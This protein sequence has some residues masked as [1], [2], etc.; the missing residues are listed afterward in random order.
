MRV[1]IVVNE[2]GG[3]AI[4]ES[5][6]TLPERLSGLF[7]A[8]G[9]DAH[10]QLARPG[11]LAEQFRSAAAA[12]PDVLV[13]VG[14]DGTVSCGADAAV[15]AGIT[16]GVIP[17]GTFNHFARD[18]RIPIALEAAVDTI[19]AG[20]VQAV[21]VAEL[22]GRVFINNSAIGLYPMMVQDRE[23]Q[24]HRLG[25]SKRVAMIVACLRAFRHFHRHRLAVRI[26]G[27]EAPISTPLMFVGN[28][29][30]ETALLTMGR[31]A[32]LD[33]GVLSIRALLVESPLHLLGLALRGLFWGFDQQRD[34]ANLDS[35]REAVI[36]SLQP[37]LRVSLDGETHLF[38]T[39]LRYR[40]LPRAL[41][42]LVPAGLD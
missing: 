14:G 5:R 41:H 28:N 38:E 37:A 24:R 39:P 8:R 13:A 36:L 2:S 31:R 15:K 4:G 30:Y 7:R 12:R 20:R 6:E 35:A 22:N 42:L 3:N 27:R 34:F 40:I 10:V 11:A 26:E 29:R 21:D 25:R 18:A 17:R 19:S 9:I 1:A 32:R 16:L 23:A 33:E